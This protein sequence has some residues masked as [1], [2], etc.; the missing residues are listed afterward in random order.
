M[1]KSRRCVYCEQNWPF[2]ERYDECP[3]CLE[4]T[5]FSMQ[6][7]LGEVIANELAVH[8]AFGWWLWE[9]ERV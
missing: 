9:H 8:A 6:A 7:P 4:D 2:E 1:H 3:I 5:E